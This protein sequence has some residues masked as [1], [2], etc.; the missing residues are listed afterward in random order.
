[1]TLR[2]SCV[3]LID[4]KEGHV[5]IA[6]CYEPSRIGLIVGEDSWKTGALL[7][8]GLNRRGIVTES[9]LWELLPPVPNPI[10]KPPSSLLCWIHERI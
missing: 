7:L 1:M 4:R 10:A 9:V 2:H 8:M 6:I 3:S 5:S